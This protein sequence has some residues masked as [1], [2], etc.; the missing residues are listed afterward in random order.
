MSGAGFECEVDRRRE[1]VRLVVGG[2]PVAKVA[3]L[4]GRSRWWVYEWLGRFEEFGD[5]GLVDQSR[6]PLS[7]PSKTEQDVIDRVLSKRSELKGDPV[8]SIGALTILAELEREGFDRV[9]SLRT[10]E[11]ILQQA[12][13]TKPSRKRDRSTEPKLPLP[14]VT[15]P[16]V[17]QQ[18]DW[19]Q[20]RWLT[21]GIRFNSIQ[22]TDVGSHGVA[23]HQYHQRTM[24]NA[25]SFLINHA[26]P[27]LSIPQAMG[28]D[29]A[30]SKTTHRH[31]PFTSWVRACLWFGTETIVTPPGTHGWNNH[32]EHINN[33]W[34]KRTIWATRFTNLND[35]RKES[36][37]AINWL[38]TRRPIL[39]P[40]ITGTRYPAEYIANNKHNLRWP[41]PITLEDQFGTDNKITIPLAAGRITFLRHKQTNHTIEI[42]NHHWPIPESIPTGALIMATLTTHN[43]QL[44][45]R[46]QGEHITNHPYPINHP[47]TNPYYPPAKH[48][49]LNHV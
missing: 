25:V 38:N 14:Q 39:N 7:R 5:D 34:Q 47:I 12:R 3:R 42:A 1:A 46:H 43:H 26:W 24:T 21:G 23:S 49:L 29:N 35:L 2:V 9:P 15:T 45:I 17:W 11:R 27:T 30:F 32:V 20:N 31:N 19:V 6:A 44:E 36:D 18:A 41:P 8:A 10:I 13:V 33:E 16:G 37:R 4:V 40:A 22:V 48:S 28:I